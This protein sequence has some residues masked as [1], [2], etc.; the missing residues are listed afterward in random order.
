MASLGLSDKQAQVSRFKQLLSS[1][2]FKNGDSLSRLYTGTGALK[3]E[4]KS[5]V[6]VCVCGGGGGG[7]GFAPLGTMYSMCQRMMFGTSAIKILLLKKDYG[8]KRPIAFYLANIILSCRF[9]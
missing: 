4:G 5:K 3:F 8:P 7:G 9:Y 6:S 2:W 1:A